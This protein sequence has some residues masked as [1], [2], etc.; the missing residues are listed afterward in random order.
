MSEQLEEMI[1]DYTDETGTVFYSGITDNFIGVPIEEAIEK[2][3]HKNGY[4]ENN[5]LCDATMVHRNLEPLDGF[6][7]ITISWVDKI[8]ER[9]KGY[10]FTVKVS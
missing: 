6:A 7:I 1:K 9:L 5:F 8:S 4:D 2:L 3:F 10:C